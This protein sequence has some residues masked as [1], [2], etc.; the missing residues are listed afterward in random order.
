MLRYLVTWSIL[1]LGLEVFM[2]I[3]DKNNIY[4][5]MYYY[6]SSFKITDIYYGEGIIEFHL[7]YLTAMVLIVPILY[8][9]V[10]YNLINKML[11]L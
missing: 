7:W 9:T 8:F 2:N 6:F 4:E 5:L 1:Y 3:L 10:K 11:I